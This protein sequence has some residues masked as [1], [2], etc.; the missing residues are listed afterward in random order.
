MTTA[1]ARRSWFEQ[2]ITQ[3][4]PDSPGQNPAWLDNARIQA[5]QA[6]AELPVPNRKQENWRYSAVEGLLKNSF[7]PTAGDATDLQGLDPQ[8][9]L[10]PSFETYRL[11]FAN[12]HYVPQLSNGERLPAGVTL[13]NLR[14][15]LASDSKWIANWFGQAAGHTEHLF[16]AL[17]TA[18]ANDGALLH[19]DENTE[20]ERPIEVIYLNP[21]QDDASLIQPRNLVV[22]EAGARATLVERFIG[23]G[24]AR[25]FNNNLTEIA[26]REG[27][28]LAHYR[29]QDESRNA[30]HLGSLYLSQAQQS[31]YLGTTLAFGGA[32][33]RTDYNARFRHEGAE[34]VLNGLYTAGDRQLTDFHLNVQH[35]VPGCTSR[36]RFKGILYGKGRAVFDGRILV[37][38]QAQHSDAH[39][40]ND[41]LMLTR[42]AEVDTKPQLEIYADNVKC[43]HGTTVGQLDPEQVFYLRSRGITASA[44]HRMLCLGFAG[45]I[46]DSI[47]LQ[48]LRDYAAHRLAATLNEAVVEG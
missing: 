4:G 35:S 8:S 38:R 13:G 28:A 37:D 41:N 11:V 3:S 48:P 25:Y 9:W 5:R 24:E 30:W 43:S 6:I 14:T 23:S 19:I 33:A 42:N 20:V 44:A 31:R 34:C 32:W 2:L 7:Q 40:T 18:L 47:E 29:I 36:E 39:L 1:D 15:A 17:N 16:T 21:G 26:L 12:G 27:A 22:L 46:I 10:L 45:E